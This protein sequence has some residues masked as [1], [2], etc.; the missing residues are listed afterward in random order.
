MVVLPP[1]GQFN[2]SLLILGKPGTCE[3][4]GMFQCNNGKCVRKYRICNS[5]NDCGDNSDESRNDG[6]FVVCKIG[7]SMH[8][9][10]IFD[11]IY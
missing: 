8:L 7:S 11:Q 9:T 4:S 1:S 6:P 5:Y 3:K 10:E 2:S